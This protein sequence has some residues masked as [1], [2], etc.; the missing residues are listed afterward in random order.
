MFCSVYI[1]KPSLIIIVVEI[2]G[3][4][5]NSQNCSLS[6]VLALGDLNKGANVIGCGDQ[7]KAMKV[8]KVKQVRYQSSPSE[9]A[10]DFVPI[11]WRR[12]RPFIDGK[13][14]AMQEDHVLIIEQP[15]M[16]AI[17]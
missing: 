5:T 17:S 13:W 10:S 12:E 15:S 3:R 9:N 16:E 1:A 11:K 7:I 6:S 8:S 14:S 2:L 4:A